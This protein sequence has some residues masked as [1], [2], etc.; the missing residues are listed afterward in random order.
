MRNEPS[1]LTTIVE[2]PERKLSREMTNNLATPGNKPSITHL[3]ELAIHGLELMY[4]D[5]EE[6]FC[7]RLKQTSSGT[8]KEGISQ[9]YTIMTLLGL[10]RA[11]SAGYQS[12]VDIYATIDALYSNTEWVDNIGDL[13]LLLWLSSVSSRKL[14]TFCA[15]F[16]LENALHNYSDARKR[17]TMELAWFLT[18]LTYASRAEEKQRLHL[19]PL[20]RRTY[21]SLQS[22]QGKHG[23]FGHMA[24]RSS[25][26]GAVR[27]HVGSFA[28]QVYPIFAMA[29]FG[30]VFGMKEALQNSL[31]CAN[32]ICRL[33]GPLGQWWWHYDAA[34][35]RVVERYPVYSV[36]QHGMA[37][38]ALFATQDACHAD[39]REQIYKGLKWIS[40]ANELEQELENAAA[41]VVWR[42]IRPAKW[43]SYAARI[44]TLVGEEP[45]LGAAE[46]LFECRPYE[47]G[48]LLYAHASPGSIATS[49]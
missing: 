47:L 49:A 16:D 44:R 6:L 33:Q 41:G 32:A 34:S 1:A 9:R 46:I 28:D 22:N 12:P 25:L 42:C 31:Q 45:D 10:L 38:M 35:G 15:T 30:Q 2:H 14:D 4:D 5:E 21:A 29:Q 37:P 40:G 19:E 27:G 13:G 8:S 24:K 18:G 20:A 48:W 26:A 23:L 43:A 36:H 3:V 11:E 39:F 17:L 7:H